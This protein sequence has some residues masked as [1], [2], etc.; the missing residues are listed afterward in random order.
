LGPN[1]DVAK[2]FAE[3][4]ALMDSMGKSLSPAERAAELAAAKQ[5]ASNFR[6]RQARAN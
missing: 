5:I 2:F 4:S 3:D 1:S 6:Q